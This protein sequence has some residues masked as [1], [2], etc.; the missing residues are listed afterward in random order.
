ML[1]DCENPRMSRSF[2]ISG[3]ISLRCIGG[4]L[5]FVSTDISLL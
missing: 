3:W 1:H 4:E 2:K 5:T